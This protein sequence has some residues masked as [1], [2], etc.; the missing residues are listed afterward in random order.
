MRPKAI[1]CRR[2]RAPVSTPALTQA[3]GSSVLL[4]RPLLRGAFLGALLFGGTWGCVAGVDVSDEEYDA[5]SQSVG[6]VQGGA[7]G[8]GSSGTGNITGGTGSSLGGSFGNTGGS[9]GSSGSG[10]SAQGG[11]GGSGSGGTGGNTAPPPIGDC[12]DAVAGSGNIELR[13]FYT[14]RSMAAD[15]EMRFTLRV[16]N[17]GNGF[18]LSQLTL[19][20][21]FDDDG[22]PVNA[23]DI[24]FASTP[25]K[26]TIT[27]G[28]A[29]GSNYAQLAFSDTA[30][31]G[32][33]VQQIQ[34]RLRDPSYQTTP[35]PTND[36]SY[37][38]GAADT[39]NRQVSAY[40]MGTKVFGCEPG[41]GT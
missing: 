27:F 18:P 4:G 25:T 29:L 8:T 22:F 38:V 21:W 37:S 31:I 3:A 6:G 9:G 12:A 30:D 26:P 19:R 36:F 11:T 41:S 40:V 39:E 17:V 14:E 35:N 33:G 10:G 34:V 16:E 28:E 23:G 7:G 5:I 32:T 2:A 20:Y 1:F 13:V 15:K 24:D